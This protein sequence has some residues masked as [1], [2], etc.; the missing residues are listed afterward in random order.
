M[1]SLPQHASDEEPPD[2][3]AGGLVGCPLPVSAV[4]CVWLQSMREGPPPSRPFASAPNPAG[5]T[6]LFASVQQSLPTSTQRPPRRA[7]NDE[8]P[9]CQAQR[10][11]RGQGG[12]AKDSPAHADAADAGPDRGAVAAFVKLVPLD[13]LLEVEARFLAVT[14]IEQ[15][16]RLLQHDHAPT[17]DHHLAVTR[18][19]QS[20]PRR[21]R[22]ERAARKIESEMRSPPPTP[23]GPLSPLLSP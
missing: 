1:P 19:S 22:A 11:Y 9:G 15:P 12:A 14:A 20:A 4:A 18:M 13:A 5:P 7:A 8:P 6:R 23:R 17:D 16:K 21:K 3:D 2:D 10:N